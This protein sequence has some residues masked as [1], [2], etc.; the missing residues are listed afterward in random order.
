MQ[1]DFDVA[2]GTGAEV[3]IDLN[4]QIKALATCSS[5][6][7]AP[8]T[9]LPF[10]LWLDTSNSTY[11]YLKM[12]NHDSTAWNTLGIY[13]VSTKTYTSYTEDNVKLTTD[14]SVSGI[15]SFSSKILAPNLAYKDTLV[16]VNSWS[17]S[18]TTITLNVA[19][20]T[21]VAGDYIEVS[22]LT[23][24][25]NAPNGV[26][27]VTSVTT[28]TIVFTAYATPTGTAGVST[29][30]VK[31]FATVNGKLPVLITAGANTSL[32]TSGYDKLPS[33]LIIQWFGVSLSAVSQGTFTFPISFPTSMLSIAITHNATTG[34]SNPIRYY[35]NTVSS[36]EIVNEGI[37]PT[38]AR[39]IAIGY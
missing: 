23:S 2:N 9:I 36:I 33:G 20:H 4:N 17:Y 26:F 7:S 10:M 12:R 30:R 28:G 34:Q 39:C 5:G 14:Q 35:N 38:I 29:A 11:Y 32:A 24:T 31:G 21:F 8:T 1:A 18:G 6:S 15:K 22:G 16:T 27:L 13:T 37:N 3:R 25:T 19:S